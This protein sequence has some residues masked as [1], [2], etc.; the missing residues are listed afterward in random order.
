M[1]RQ[2]WTDAPTDSSLALSSSSTTTTT[3]VLQG[4]LCAHQ[5]QLLGTAGA[6]EC[7]ARQRC[8]LL[9]ELQLRP[10][11]RQC[12]PLVLSV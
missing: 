12:K 4:D 10:V 2:D 1:H 6:G 8:C 7:S 5:L 3:S 11:V 9:H